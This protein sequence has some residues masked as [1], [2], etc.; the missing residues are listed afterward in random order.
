MKDDPSTTRPH[1]QRLGASFDE[2]STQATR[3]RRQELGRFATLALH[4][5]IRNARLYDTN[6]A[7]FAAPVAQL[8]AAVRGLVTTDGDFAFDLEGDGL[9]V[10]R[11]ALRFEAGVL[12]VVSLLRT[13]LTARGIN[14]VRA[15][16]APPDSDLRALIGLLQGAPRPLTAQGD[17][18]H[19]LQVLRLAVSGAARGAI[20]PRSAVLEDR[21]IGTYAQAAL[22]VTR[23]I[24]QLRAGGELTP[25]WAVSRL[26]QGLVDLE[27]EAPLRFLGLARA[28]GEG[29]AY[30]GHH[31]ANV[32]V[33]AIAFGARVGVPKRRRHELG[34]SALFHD[35]GLAALPSAVLENARELDESERA[36]LEAN[37]LFA[38]R[39][40]LRDREVH[41]A[42]LERAMAAYE[43]HLDVVRD[44]G[45]PALL[46]FCGRVLALCEAFDALTSA[47]PYRGAYTPADALTV[48][49]TELS[50]RFD[51]RLLA[52]FP[53]VVAPLTTDGAAAPAEP[54]LEPLP[55][56]AFLTAVVEP[57]AV[58]QFAVVPIALEPVA[59]E[60]LAVVPV[61]LEPVAV[62]PVA[63]PQP[64]SAAEPASPAAQ[65]KDA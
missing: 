25:L 63:K 30:W 32:A 65:A 38:A 62:E 15:A 29:D 35:I 44:G 41:P 51:P 55:E 7:V 26:V 5:M 27:R 45:D 22:F 23:Y 10:N 21:L 60:Q 53:S 36:A 13:E 48:M 61:A 50:T 4:S 49:E 37:P 24:V 14:G 9:R 18:T 16:A 64:A 58:E 43:C 20:D 12:P 42:A 31:A 19:K 33:L 47:R 52:L 39:A 34:M 40:T 28:K 6:N 17:A 2:R 57:L 56:E 59:V 8:G 54:P 1:L 3:E 46:G 11:Q